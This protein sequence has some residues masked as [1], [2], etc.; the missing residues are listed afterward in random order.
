MKKKTLLYVAVLL[1]VVLSVS[2][3]AAWFL[4]NQPNP[5]ATKVALVGDSITEGSS[6]VPNL[7]ALLG[8]NYSVGNFGTG[9]ASVTLASN[10]P[11][12][13]QQ[14][15][16]DAKDFQPDIVVIMLGTND[17]ITM[18]QPIIGNFSADYKQLIVGF[19]RTSQQTKRLPCGATTDF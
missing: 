14:I 19:P 16:E 12:A 4:A 17:A 6:Y 13:N 9:Y 15:F 10:K 1:A 5:N 11:Y 18:Y 7:A 3:L 2:A 8:A